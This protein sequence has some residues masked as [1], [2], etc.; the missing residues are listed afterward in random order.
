MAVTGSRL[1]R[2]LLPGPAVTAVLTG[3]D[4]FIYYIADC[5]ADRRRRSP[6]LLPFEWR[7]KQAKDQ[8]GEEQEDPGK[9][10]DNPPPPSDGQPPKAAMSFFLIPGFCRCGCY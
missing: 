10:I 7:S 4:G 9:E 1:H 2:S 3:A 8:S 5:R 6:V